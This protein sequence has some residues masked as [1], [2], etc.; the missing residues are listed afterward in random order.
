MVCI[1][2]IYGFLAQIFVCLEETVT[3]VDN[4]TAI[5]VQSDSLTEEEY[6]FL[7]TLID[8]AILEFS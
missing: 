4:T 6:T 5:H 7:N 8:F 3:Q 1:H 2:K